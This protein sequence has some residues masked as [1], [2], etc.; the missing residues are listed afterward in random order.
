[1]TEIV[2]EDYSGFPDT[3]ANDLSRESGEHSEHCQINYDEG[4]DV[5]TVWFG[6]DA[7]GQWLYDWLEET[8]QYYKEEYVDASGEYDAAR[9]IADAVY[10]EMSSESTQ[11]G[12]Q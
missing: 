9:E 7:A 10:G 1:M 11:E 5:V 4:R 12:G 8:A 3:I 2:I 6:S